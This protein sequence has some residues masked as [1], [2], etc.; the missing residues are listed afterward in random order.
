MRQALA[1]SYEKDLFKLMNNTIYRKMMQ[2]NHRHSCVHIITSA[3][4]V[5][6]AWPTFKNFNIVNDDVTVVNLTESNILLNKPIY[7]RKYILDIS[8]LQMYSFDYSQSLPSY[9]YLR[10]W[11]V[12]AI[13]FEPTMFTQTCKSI[14]TSMTPQTTPAAIFFSP[15]QMQRWS[16]NSNQESRP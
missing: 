5:N 3:R 16:A 13:T 14:W 2:N 9:Y 6:F 1:S 12:N 10:T 11:T 8:K 4:C 15:R 7:I